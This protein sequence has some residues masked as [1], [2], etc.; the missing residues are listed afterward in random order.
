VK[1][2]VIGLL[3]FCLALPALATQSTIPGW[4]ELTD[5]QKAEVNLQVARQAAAK[6][7]IPIKAQDMQEWVDLG[8]S[9]G[10]GFASTAHELGMG[11]DK[12]MDT[13]TGKIAMFLI[14]WN[15]IGDQFVGIVG[16][17]LW[18]CIMLPAWAYYFKRWTLVPTWEWH[19]NGKRKSLTYEKTRSANAVL[20]FTIALLIILGAGF[21]LIF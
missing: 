3:M 2:L 9:I 1:K 14:V 12:L 13:T 19:N 16:G 18:L 10:V 6:K 20:Y 8:K 21:I 15:Y 17:V 7:A 11:V 5:Q 4:N